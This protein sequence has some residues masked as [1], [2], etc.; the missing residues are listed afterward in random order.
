M[1]LFHFFSFHHFMYLLS[2]YVTVSR[3]YYGRCS[4]FFQT[5]PTP[6]EYMSLA[7]TNAGV[8]LG[9]RG[10]HPIERAAGEGYIII[11]EKLSSRVGCWLSSLC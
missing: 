3:R 11:G 8:S 10:Y 5:A 2:L 9:L 7:A 4:F 1:F 6:C